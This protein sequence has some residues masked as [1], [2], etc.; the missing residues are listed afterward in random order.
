MYV[1]RYFHYSKGKKMCKALILLEEVC[2]LHYERKWDR[3]ANIENLLKMV[4]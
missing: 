3:N 2:N 4:V 1:M